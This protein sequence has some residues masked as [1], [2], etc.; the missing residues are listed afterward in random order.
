MQRRGLI[1]RI[2]RCVLSWLMQLI[3]E[4]GSEAADVSGSERI[5]YFLFSF[6]EGHWKSYTI[7]LCCRLGEDWTLANEKKKSIGQPRIYPSYSQHVLVF[8]LLG[9]ASFWSILL[10]KFPP[11]FFY[12]FFQHCVFTFL[13][14]FFSQYYSVSSISMIAAT[15]IFFSSTQ[16]CNTI[17]GPC[18]TGLLQ[19]QPGSDIRPLSSTLDFFQIPCQSQSSFPVQSHWHC[20]TT[21]PCHHFRIARYRFDPYQCG[22]QWRHCGGCGTAPG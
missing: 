3:S 16:L 8:V 17:V 11:A 10:G 22:T 15:L 19:G 1:Q 20:L 5:I 7:G 4:V 12:F 6:T 18:W 14:Y 21:L 9:W 13:L 2:L